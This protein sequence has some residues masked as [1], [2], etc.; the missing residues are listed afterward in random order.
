[1]HNEDR[2]IYK[3]AQGHGSVRCF[4]FSHWRMACD[5][6]LGS[7]KLFLFQFLDRPVDD[8]TIFGMDHGNNFLLPGFEQNIQ[9]L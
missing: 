8:C 7:E 9:D 5:V 2:D 4:N 1:M 6:V 3:L